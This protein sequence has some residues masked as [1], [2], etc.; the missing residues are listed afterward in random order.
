MHFCLFLAGGRRLCREVNF[1]A[2]FLETACSFYSAS[3][4]DFIAPLH[5]LKQFGLNIP[6]ST[7][8]KLPEQKACSTQQNLRARSFQFRLIRRA[9][10]NRSEWKCFIM[11]KVLDVKIRLERTR[12]GEGGPFL[13]TRTVHAF[14]ATAPFSAFPSNFLPS[15]SFLRSVQFKFSRLNLTTFSVPLLADQSL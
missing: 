7:V 11:Q 2:L 5:G 12:T 1:A 14:Q 6:C 13:P 15:A 4:S 3:G 10:P 8:L 9:L